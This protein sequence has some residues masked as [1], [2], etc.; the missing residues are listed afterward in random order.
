M[1]CMSPTIQLAGGWSRFSSID[2]SA[3]DG[4]GSTGSTGTLGSTGTAAWRAL[5]KELTTARGTAL[6]LI[7][8]GSVLCEHFCPPDFGIA[9]D[10][11]W[12]PYLVANCTLCGIVLIAD[13]LPAD[14]VLLGLSVLF[15]LTGII[16][17]RQAFAG[18]A[19]P[20]VAAYAALFILSE[21]FAEVKVL[22]AV[23]FRL[24]GH[25][26][27]SL[28]MAQLRVTA[29]VAA[30]SAMFNNGPLVA[31]LVPL[32]QAWALRHGHHAAQLLMPLAFAST[33]GGTL[34]MIG[35]AANLLAS[36]CARSL[37]DPVEL[38]LFALTPY[39]LPL[40]FIG[41][42]FMLLGAPRLLPQPQSSQSSSNRAESDVILP[43]QLTADEEP[44]VTAAKLRSYHILFVV[45]RRCPSI[46]S[47]LA[48]LGLARLPG[49]AVLELKRYGK[50]IPEMLCTP[51]QHG[52]VLKVMANAASIAQLRRSYDG[53]EPA[54]HRDLDI[55]GGRRRHRR[56]FEVVLGAN[57]E[58]LKAPLLEQKQRLL[59]MGCV[60]LALRHPDGGGAT[61]SGHIAAGD[62]LLVEAFPGIDGTA[63][64]AVIA[65]VDASK[66]PRS[67]RQQD[68]M[69]GLLCLV[70]FIVVILCNGFSILPLATAMLVLDFL[71]CF[72]KVLGWREALPSVNGGVIMTIASSFGISAALTQTG[73]A[74][75]LANALLSAGLSFGP[76]GV[77][78]TLYTGTALLTN[79]ISNTATCV[80][81]IPVA[82]HISEELQGMENS[83]LNLKTLIIMVILASNAAFATPLGS[84]CN[85]LVVDAGDYELRDFLRFGGMLQL[86]LLVSTCTLLYAC[87]C[88]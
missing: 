19:S 28:R 13:G 38:K 66:P 83:E 81:M 4:R 30:A 10:E 68:R 47:S 21:A 6:V 24:L 33:L 45:R 55:L 82:A 5:G 40:N 86:V 78:I 34:T 14:A 2:A 39:S 62:I 71:C 58:L 75:A 3:L 31:M 48:D 32:V 53:L 88:T 54:V 79:I 56:L 57:S 1:E 69:R 50:V 61:P 43:P 64:F 18:F 60:I 15:V 84:P 77:L 63:D 29:P 49:V 74:H 59:Q 26:N 8:L 52:D 12:K 72:A 51:L 73:A 35:S 7:L 22:D 42:G 37:K 9:A 17:E 85:L 67:G 25:Q 27:T 70:G 16:S 44:A 46:G 76:L 23:M 80:M 87:P 11:R 65:P 36:D 41:V 20:G